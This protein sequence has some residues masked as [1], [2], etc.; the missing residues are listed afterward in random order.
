M[1]KASNPLPRTLPR[2]LS[3]V[4]LEV[5]KER[6]YQ[7]AKWGGPE[8]DDQYT[9]EEFLR[10]VEKYAISARVLSSM[11]SPE[12]ARHRLIRVAALAIA[13]V[14]S[15]D[16]KT[17]NLTP[18]SEKLQEEPVIPQPSPETRGNTRG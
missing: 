8:H 11:D 5:S 18:E 7:D 17:S 1:K 10:L 6:V 15:I 14:E 3:P 9:A 13:A 2:P 16:R 4:H 12:K